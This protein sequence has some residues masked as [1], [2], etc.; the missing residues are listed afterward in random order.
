M[1]SVVRRTPALL[2]LGALACA[3]GVLFAGS[4]DV[5]WN[6]DFYVEAWPA[7]KALIAGDLTATSPTS[8]AT[9]ASS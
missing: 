3:L 1:T 4:R 9:P 6:G 7:Y 2:W 8:R 5:F